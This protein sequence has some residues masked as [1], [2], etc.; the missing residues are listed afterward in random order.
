MGEMQRV[1]GEGLR[2]RVIRGDVFHAPEAGGFIHMA[3]AAIAIDAGGFIAMVAAAGTVEHAALCDGMG[4]GVA[5]LPEGMALLP[6]FV[7][8][9]V[10]APQFPQLGLALDVP[11]ETW[12]TRYTFPLEARY[13][14]RDFAAEAYGQL[15]DDLLAGGTTT[16][17][18]FATIHQQA[19]RL[20]V[21]LCLA[22]GQRALVGKVAMDHPS[23]PDYYRDADAEAA[24]AGTRALIDYVRAHPDNGE[25][26]VLP[27]ITPRFI[28]A[29][30]D[31]A[32]AGLGM[33][34][35][36]TGAHVHTHCSESDWAHGHVLERHGI[37]DAESLDRFGLLGR[38]SV[39]AHANF[40]SASDMDLL[41]ERG[42]GVAHCALS[43]AYF[44]NA[45]FPLR[46]ALARGVH[47]GLGTDISGGPSASML[48]AQRMSVAASRMLE[49]G[50]DPA[51]P[52]DGRGR[53]DSRI[54]IA[55]AFHLAT[56]GGA[57]A[58]DLPVGSFARGKLF[59]A[60]AID[61]QAP[62]GSIRLFG[63]TEPADILAAILYTAS[64]PNIA[65]VW[66]GGEV[67]RRHPQARAF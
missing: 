16:A 48:D 59:D 45:V 65:R 28:P 20:L 62:E 15:V 64:R 50:V 49:D 39:L 57:Q 51:L 13:S 53:P 35:G 38:R 34:A 1:N 21:D 25:A 3:D 8:C 10:H 66:V 30:S 60:I 56:A 47:V 29:C 46:E 43:N 27:V 17:L 11:L 61:T 12:L 6:G 19:T 41:A 37:S 32:L 58:L 31:E 22:K 7:D 23:C 40:L 52:R 54:D 4:D 24:V 2:G 5:V 36:Q 18:Y 44:A 33:L 55:T 42:A 63:Q 9:H 14:D 67:V 26:L